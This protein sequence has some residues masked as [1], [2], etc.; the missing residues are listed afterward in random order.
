M[1]TE[2]PEVHL[3]TR[4]NYSTRGEVV[5]PGALSSLAEEANPFA[6]RAAHHSERSSGRRLA[7]A[8]WVT[9]PRSRAAALMA[10]VQVNRLWQ[11]YFGK[12]IVATPD[13]LGLSGAPPSHPE[14]LDWLASEL[15]L[16]GWSMK[17][18]H[19]MVLH[20]A[21]Y[22]RS[23]QLQD[24]SY[25]ADPSNRLLWRFTSRRL[26][27]EAI[28]DQMLAVSGELD[29]ALGGPYIPTSRLET[30]EIVAPEGEAISQRRTLYLNQ[31]RTQVVSFLSVFDSP[32]I[33]F[34][35]VRRNT[36]T[37]PLQSLSL[38]NSNFARRRARAAA[39]SLQMQ[40]SDERHRLK[41]AF[42]VFYSRYPKDNELNESN[43]FLDQQANL[44][45][46]QPDAKDRA[47]QDLCQSLMAS[48][49][50]MYVE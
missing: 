47:W 10:R 33:V 12:G 39:T 36:S 42:L 44:Y 34:N 32:S 6:V 50:F 22:R 16:N 9:Q 17:S 5:E 4:G 25:Q 13:N 20:S 48:S 41:L 7:W 21:A 37:M 1:A 14:L 24:E 28:R 45:F 29:S 38:L 49:E 40:T 43:R 30:G 15:I 11:Q 3:L 46:E 2:L 8:E 26:D 35:S 18:I 27:A 23:S 19:R 31:K